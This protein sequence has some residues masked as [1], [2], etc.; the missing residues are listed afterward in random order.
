MEMHTGDAE[1]PH[2]T[3]AGYRR[4]CRCARC[5]EGWRDYFRARR[6]W[7]RPRPEPK[8]K[9]QP[10]SRVFYGGKVNRP[11]TLT[12]TPL[13]REILDAVRRRTDRSIG[14]IVER[15]LRQYGADLAF[16]KEDAA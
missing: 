8:P 11:V 10:R 4:A 6:G 15:L 1:F 3:V 2:G 7:P 16:G 13:G 12:L 14:D 9:P 5:R